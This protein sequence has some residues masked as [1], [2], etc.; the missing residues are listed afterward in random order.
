MFSN[1]EYNFILLPQN[2]Q[3]SGTMNLSRINFDNSHKLHI[4][5]R[6]G[7]TK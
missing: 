2:H 3:P 1:N 4:I 7:A 5:K 6:L